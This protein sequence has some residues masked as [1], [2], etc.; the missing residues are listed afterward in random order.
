MA[1]ITTVIICGTL[2]IMPR[3]LRLF[4]TK[5][6]SA[7]ASGSPGNQY[8]GSHTRQKCFSARATP[9]NTAD[10]WSAEQTNT[11]L[12]KVD[13]AYVP[14]KENNSSAASTESTAGKHNA[15]IHLREFDG[16]DEEGDDRRIWKT[17]RVEQSF[18][19]T[20]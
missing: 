11:A 5:S 13:K 2:P 3:F 18:L 17:V 12:A 19:R 15:T 16:G 8:Y 9:Q 10:A 6:A 4:R 1:E 14:L 7:T 20:D